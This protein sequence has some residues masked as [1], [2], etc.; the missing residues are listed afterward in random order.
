MKAILY[1]L[2]GFKRLC[3]YFLLTGQQYRD[4]FARIDVLAITLT[5]DTVEP[6]SKGH[7]GNGSFVLCSE[8]V[9]ISEVQL[10]NPQ[11]ML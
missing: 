4:R 1:I 9:P 5:D 10:Y 11:I 6:L 7:F 8:V 2:M 3:V